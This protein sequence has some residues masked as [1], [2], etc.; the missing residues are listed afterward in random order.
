MAKLT[1]RGSVWYIIYA[2]SEGR[3]KRLSTR[4]GVK[5]LARERLVA[6]EYSRSLPPA[7]DQQTVNKLIEAYLIDRKDVVASH[8]S[9]SF[10][11]AKIIAQLGDHRPKQITMMA[12][13]KYRQTRLNDGV[14]DGTIIKELKTLRAALSFGVKQGWLVVPPYIELPP[15]PTPKNRWLTKKEAAKLIAAAKAPHV[16]LFLLLA[17]YTGARRGAI[18][19]LTWDRVA[20]DFKMINFTLPGRPTSKKRRT[21]VPT[22]RLV[23]AMLKEACEL[24]QTDWVIEYNGKPSKTMRTGFTNA[25]NNSG[26]AHCTIHDLRRTCATWLIQGGVSLSRVARMLGDSEKM[27]ESVYGHHAPDYL[28]DAI[29][30]LEG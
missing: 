6:F 26:I 10:A 23:Q 7:E 14:G 20:D 18:L 16:K 21:L 30:V 29:S 3:S 1:K 15:Q 13:K 4:T 2:D 25:L 28:D 22:T 27:I 24:A 11:G 9:L 5:R 17:I 12:I 8:A 19:D